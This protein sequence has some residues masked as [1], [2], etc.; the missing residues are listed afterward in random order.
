[1]PLQLPPQPRQLGLILLPQRLPLQLRL[2]AL[3][4]QAALQLA[5]GLLL[6]QQA[7]L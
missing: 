6:S 2:C 4:R 7:C 5:A 3:L 1:M